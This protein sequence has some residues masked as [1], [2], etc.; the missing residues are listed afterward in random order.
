MQR[1]SVSISALLPRLLP[2]LNDCS[3][4]PH[5]FVYIRGCLTNDTMRVTHRTGCSNELGS[6]SDTQSP[7]P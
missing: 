4:A 2:V 3:A 5:F 1:Y 6:K 7:L